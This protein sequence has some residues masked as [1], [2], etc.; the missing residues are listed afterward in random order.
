MT[1]GFVAD[2]SVA[3]AWVVRS[4]SSPQCDELLTGIGEG[5][6]FIVP[7]LWMMEVANALLMLTRR[8]RI[9]REHGETARRLLRQL[10]PEVD[11]EGP[12]I[13]LD[14]VYDLAGQ[15]AL[16]VYDA[17]YLELSLR[18]GLP[19]ASRDASLRKAAGR[20]GVDLLA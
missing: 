4:Q 3:M 6:P 15:H 18:R 16:S 1:G 19:L 12:A 13:S 5:R 9:T 11:G 20:C 17:V 8:K 14:R 7:G 10:A 2:S